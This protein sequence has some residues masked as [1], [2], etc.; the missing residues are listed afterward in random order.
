MSNSQQTGEAPVRRPSP[1]AGPSWR[2][3]GA[4]QWF[5]AVVGW[6]A[7]A[8]VIAVLVL[9]WHGADRPLTI[10]LVG[11]TPLL[12]VP[13]AVAVAGSWRARSRTLRVVTGVTAAS[14]LVT[15]SPV[16]AVIGCQADEAGDAI[17]IYSANVLYDGGR[18][19]DVVTSILA[20][21]ADV[22]VLQEVRWPFL[23]E[24]REDPRLADWV[25]R[26][27]DAPSA[28]Q[29]NL[30]WSRWPFADLTVDPFVSSQLVTAVVDGPAGPFAVTVVHTLAPSISANVPIWTAQL[31][32]LATVDTSTPHM[33]V[34]DFNATADHR[35]FRSLFGRGWTDVHERKGC[36]F[37]ATW[38]VDHELPFAVMR[39]DHALV[40][41]HFEVLDVR[42]GEPAGSDHKPLVTDVRL[43]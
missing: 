37:D 32:Q 35:Q 19:D 6:L 30:I 43:D 42:F 12:F 3:R 31:A 1:G 16:D 20:E 26:S 21:D 7:A 36:G 8:A 24:L 25:H 33:L 18:A 4:A 39:L 9:R 34:G 23:K 27:D 22:V 17:T 13:L 15:V 2:S 28:P 14:F 41:D 5:W 10:A 29:G 11:L 40:T 38:P